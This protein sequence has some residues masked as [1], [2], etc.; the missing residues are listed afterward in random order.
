MELE[1]KRKEEEEKERKLAEIER[2]KMEREREIEEKM[3]RREQEERDSRTKD[4]VK[5]EPKDAW[6]RPTE[7][8]GSWRKGQD[9]RTPGR[10]QPPSRGMF[11]RFRYFRPRLH[12]IVFIRKR[13]GNVLA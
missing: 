10:D 4:S 1:A 3:R 5:Q 8:A 7:D 11:G 12:Y 2:K 6:R 13:Y 9:S